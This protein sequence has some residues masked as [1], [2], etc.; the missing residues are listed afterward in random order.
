MKKKSRD[1][2]IFEDRSDKN[3]QN[4]NLKPIKGLIYSAAQ[5]IGMERSHNEDSI[6]TLSINYTSEQG[7]VHHFGLFIIADG[8]GG[9][10]HGEVASKLATQAMSETLLEELI[11]PSIFND[12]K[13]SFEDVRDC[14]D[15]GMVL[16]QK[17]VLSQVPG[18]GTTLTATLIFGDHLF[19]THVGDSRLYL[20]DSESNLSLVTKDHSLV[21]RLVELGQ[22]SPNEAFIHPQRNVLFRALGQTDAFKA[23]TGEF[24]L[25]S[26]N[27]LLLCTDGLWGQIPDEEVLKILRQES[28]SVES[29]SKL[30]DA[31][32]AAGGSDNISVILVRLL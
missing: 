24:Q 5:S 16:A 27:S 23:D 20:V 13:P 6:F 25:T 1:Q 4:N 9:H 30:I 19:Y 18:G 17:R 14:L 8:M 11:K 21:R 22:I 12:H 29:V 26:G 3:F 2:I 31:A 28:F 32:N 10:A 7:Y 15:H